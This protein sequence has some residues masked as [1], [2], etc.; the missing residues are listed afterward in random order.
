MPRLGLALILPMLALLLAGGSVAQAQTSATL[1]LLHLSDY[2]SHG[3]SFYSESRPDQGG[4][5]RTIGYLRGQR[6]SNPNTIAFS[7]GDTMNVGSPSWSDKYLCSE[8]DWFNGLLDAM[9]FGNHD[10]V[11]TAP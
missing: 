9:A 5:A 11:T 7:G 6:L 4:I 10:R 3:P 1:T 8:W 2:H